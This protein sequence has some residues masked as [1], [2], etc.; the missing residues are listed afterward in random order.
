VVDVRLPKE[1][2]SAHMPGAIINP[3]GGLRQ[4]LPRQVKDKHRV[5]LV[6]CLSGGRCDIAKQHLK[7]LGHANMFN[8]GSRARARQM[9]NGSQDQKCV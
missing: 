7:T 9:I 6:H 4:S 1:F 8:L 2:Q 3:L 5:L